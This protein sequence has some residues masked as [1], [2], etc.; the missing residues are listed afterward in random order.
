MV[1]KPFHSNVV[2]T[3]FISTRTRQPHALLR[4]SRNAGSAVL[5]PRQ[6]SPSRCSW[7]PLVGTPLSTVCHQ[8]Q[9]L[10]L[11]QQGGLSPSPC[12]PQEWLQERGVCVLRKIRFDFWICTEIPLLKA[13]QW[14]HGPLVTQSSALPLTT[15]LADCFGEPTFRRVV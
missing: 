8:D 9:L 1:L 12:F 3:E 7:C 11:L 15:L 5:Q 4:L 6:M 13:Q 14:Q 10:L 2:V